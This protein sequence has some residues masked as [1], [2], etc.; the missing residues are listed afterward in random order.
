MSL[1]IL[2]GLN[3]A[4]LL[5]Q[6][7]G[8]GDYTVLVAGGVSLG[9]RASSSRAASPTAAGGAAAGGAGSY[10]RSIRL[11]AAGGAALG[12]AST[13]ALAFVGQ[14]GGGLALGGV[15]I[16][17]RFL[18]RIYSSGGRGGPVLYGIPLDT[19]E[20][21]SWTSDALTVPGSYKFAVRTLDTFTGLEDGN[22][23][24]V[25]ELVLDADGQD[26]TGV[27]LPPV[28]LRALPRAGRALRV[29]WSWDY[30]CSLPSQRPSSFSV[31][32]A[33][34]GIGASAQMAT[35]PWSSGRAGCF[36]LNLV[37]AVPDGTPCTITVCAVNAAGLQSSPRA[38]SIAVDGTP[39]TM[40]DAL[41]I[42]A[43]NQEV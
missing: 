29:E 14:A 30:P 7:L 17:T 25:V 11:A 26:V 2:Q 13:G 16:S 24:A 43:T 36:S 39:P 20:G 21:R 22:I 27:P 19:V 31:S 41:A 1:L 33:A 28:G 34:T 35:V 9:G 4:R 37:P 40:V 15:Q 18:Y 3:G 12:G 38:V 6:G 8:S 5:L 10:R 42:A 23:D 32:L